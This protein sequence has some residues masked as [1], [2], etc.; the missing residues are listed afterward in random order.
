MDKTQTQYIEPVMFMCESKGSPVSTG[1]RMRAKEFDALN[2][3]RSFRCG[4]CGA[5][6]TWTKETAWRGQRSPQAA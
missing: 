4:A 2:G 1:H 6:H 3:P 5:I